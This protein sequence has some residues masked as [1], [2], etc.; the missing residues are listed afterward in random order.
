MKIVAVVGMTGA[1]KTEFSKLFSEKHFTRIRFGDLTDEILKKKGLEL[2]EENEKKIRE[3]IREE[4]GMEAYAKLNLS[5]I[6]EAVKNRHVVIDGMYSWEE[7]T[8]LKEKFADDLI[9]VAVFASP[10][11][12]YLRLVDREDRPLTIEQAKNRDFREI[13]ILN[14]TAPIAMADYTI[15]NIGTLHDLK[16]EHTTFMEW[17][18]ERD[19]TKLG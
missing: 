7:Y 14:K 17:M 18:H 9:V 15:L 4:H 11:I 2:N 12:R 10:H 19:E 13:K 3:S 5:K 16:E 6:L 1:G 8:F